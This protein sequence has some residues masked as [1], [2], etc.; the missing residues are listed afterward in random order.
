MSY[1]IHGTVQFSFDAI[2]QS[3]AQLVFIDRIM[4]LIFL[5]P[6]PLFVKTVVTSSVFKSLSGQPRHFEGFK[7]MV[8]MLTDKK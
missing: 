5:L 1:D 3:D 7:I 2:F 4:D 6:P 8:E